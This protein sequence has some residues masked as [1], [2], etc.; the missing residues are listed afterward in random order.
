MSIDELMAKPYWI[1]DLLPKQVPANSAG[2]Y[3]KVEQFFL[4]KIE[5]LV[6]KYCNIIL[7]MNCFCD[8]SLSHNGDEW[9]TNP[10]PE[11][12]ESRIGACL[13]KKPTEQTLYIR[14]SS[15]S[16]LMVLERD[17]TYMTIYN[18]TEELLGMLRMLASSEGLFVWKP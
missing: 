6:R 14:I 8:I 15:D 3:F 7:K 11:T 16:T 2:Q 13:N 17:C 4:K 10:D 12:M 9:V 18:P 1:I 5:T